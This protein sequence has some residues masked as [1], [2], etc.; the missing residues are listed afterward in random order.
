MSI[1][2]QKSFIVYQ[3]S[4]GAGKTYTLAKE[5]IKLC[6]MY[7]PKDP[8]LYRKI[9][10]ITFTNK[11]VNEMK[12]R[13]LLFLEL[14]SS[15]EAVDLSKE[16]SEFVD[17]KEISVRSKEI[18]H[19]IH[20]DYNSFSIYT[21]DSL[22]QRIIQSFA[23]DLKIP[24]NHQLELDANIMMSLIIDLLL[25][26]L[27]YDQAITSAIINFS[28]SNIE[29]GKNWHVEREL[30]NVGKEIYNETAIPYLKKLKTIHSE[31][32]APVIK[33]INEQI[34]TIENTISKAAKNACN[35]ILENNIQFTDFYQG[36]R[37][38][39]EW[40]NTV[41]QKNYTDLSGNGYV[42]KTINEDVWY[43][44]SCQ[45]K[46]A[47][48]AIA[49]VLKDYYLII[50]E[51]EQSYNLLKAIRKNI[52]PVILLNEIKHIAEDLKHTNKLIHISEANLSIFESI[53]NEPV[54]FIYE[55]IGEKYKYIFID[56]FQDTST[57]QWQNLL[58]L[59][60]E[61]LS[62]VLF[63]EELGKVIIF[64]DAKQAIYRFRGGNALQFVSLPQINVC[65]Q[66]PVL[67]ET[68][69][70]L[71]RNCEKMFLQTNYRSKKE[72]VEFNNL[73]FEYVIEKDY[74]QLKDIYLNA[75]QKIK[76]NNTG[77]AMFLS[78]LIKGVDGGIKYADFI[79][80]EI[81]RIIQSA[82]ADNY[83]Y[84]DMVVLVRRN[85]LG[86]EIARNLLRKN[87]PTV[88]GES[89]LLSKNK[90]V[91]FLIACL[92]CLSNNDNDIARVIMLD[93]IA[94]K[95]ETQNKEDVFMYSKNDALFKRFIK[96]CQYD[97]NANMLCEQNLY[98]RVEQLLQIFHLTREANP[99]IL[100]FLDIVANFL[101]MDNKGEVQ[102]L[103]YWEENKNKF[104]LSNP[105]GLNAVTVM[106][107]H[108]SKGL[109]FPIV[110]FPHTKKE[111]KTGEKWVDLP[112][113][114][115]KLSATILKIT[116]MKNTIYNELY[117]EEQKLILMDELNV[118][119]VA[120][121][122][123][124]DRLYF[125]AQ[126]KD[127]RGDSI[128][129]I[130]SDNTNSV[131]TL[132]KDETVE[133]YCFG[134]PQPKPSS[135]STTLQ[136]ENYIRNY[137]SKPILINSNTAKYNYLPEKNTISA[138][139]WGT[140]VHDYLAKIYR[141]TDIEFVSEL[142]RNDVNLTLETKENLLT[143]IQNIFSSPQASVLF[144]SPECEIKNEVELINTD[145]KSFRIDR[146]QIN[147]DKCTVIDYKTGLA[148]ENH[149]LQ[150]DKYKEILSAIGFEVTN[151]CLVYIDDAFKVNFH[152]KA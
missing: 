90:E 115:G 13:I 125:I 105:K 140:K 58:P 94:E 130:L 123:A 68:E 75:A 87:I 19:L 1:S 129:K 29:D 63:K 128:K 148:R 60:T 96:E 81:Y 135:N 28:F 101:N 15:S 8:F 47:I 14:L 82:Q 103:D 107:V 113:P 51:T 31:D 131:S 117:V 18:L 54:P 11:A 30:A 52:Y 12:E 106:T 56:E 20:H 27:G 49:P 7:Y 62:S 32:F 108:Q 149:H 36:T 70:I 102:F 119:Y 146:L 142:I 6:L 44:S 48:Q 66:N 2:N 24:V 144:G 69:L 134:K 93:F 23:I 88:S 72:I 39:G 124:K 80:E 150:I 26:K 132:S 95:Q 99:F 85:S 139:W 16:L 121:T 25:S 100:A 59:V 40:F 109:E 4:A 126:E 137:I 145:G 122:R 61:I 38:I 92:S 143:V 17:E 138:T 98:E 71:K 42:A 152:N 84:A 21:I 116:D 53:K 34:T 41:N 79:H 136:K 73:F 45:N 35:I 112:E 10:G 46:G 22:F 67:K 111:N 141:Q 151:T 118:D 78:Y 43:S 91:N 3:A 5:Y 120:F 76:E 97:F 33:Q 57:I 55:R 89:L 65:Y 50:S 74:P 86:A 64:G 110:I 127:V 37:G 147:G 77:G 83:N 104:S 133:Y 9:L 114:V